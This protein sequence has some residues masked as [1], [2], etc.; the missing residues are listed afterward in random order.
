[1]SAPNL[2]L[3]TVALIYAAIK[4]PYARTK[5]VPTSS[6]RVIAN[7]YLGAGMRVAQSLNDPSE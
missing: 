6:S 3:Y 4:S 1:M 7:A 2:L 5:S